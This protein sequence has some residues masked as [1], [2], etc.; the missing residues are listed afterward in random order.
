M[1]LNGGLEAGEGL[2]WDTQTVHAQV[3]LNIDGTK[4]RA[5]SKLIE[6]FGLRVVKEMTLA[7]GLVLAPPCLHYGRAQVTI[8]RNG[9]WRLPQIVNFTQPA[10]LATWGIVIVDGMRIECDPLIKIATILPKQ[11][12]HTRRDAIEKIVQAA[13]RFKGI[14]NLIVFLLV[15]RDKAIYTG[16]KYKYEYEGNVLTACF[17]VSKLKS[18][19]ATCLMGFAMKINAKLGGINRT[20]SLT[21]HF[22]DAVMVV[23]ITLRYPGPRS[24]SEAPT[25][26]NVV[27]SGDSRLS[28]YYASVGIQGRTHEAVLQ[29]EEMLDCRLTAFYQQNGKYPQSIVFYCHNTDNQGIFQIEFPDIQRAFIRVRDRINSLY[30]PRCTYILSDRLDP[31]RFFSTSTL[32]NK[33]CL[34]GTVIDAVFTRSA[35][36]FFL[37]SHASTQGTARPTHYIVLLKPEN[38]PLNEVQALTYRLC[39]IP[40]AANSA[41]SVPAPVYYAELAAKRGQCYIYPFYLGGQN[42]NKD[43]NATQFITNRWRG[44]PDSIALRETMFYL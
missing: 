11:E 42:S 32:S 44:G 34:P 38:V 21:E 40:A 9:R 43:E 14:P 31:T 39:Y 17:Q 5:G 27:A 6:R 2:D 10:T 24:I 23:G 18:H 35:D 37:L 29:L 16:I 7:R 8:D 19:N 15:N 4:L 12:D 13:S 25:I 33:N 28:Q 30:D 22:G 36:D 41:V 20:V 1:S 26:V 3:M